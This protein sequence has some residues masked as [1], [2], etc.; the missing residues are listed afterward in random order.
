MNTVMTVF[1]TE[2]WR[3][4]YEEAINPMGVPEDAWCVPEDLEDELFLVLNHAE[5]LVAQREYGEHGAKDMRRLVL[6][7]CLGHRFAFLW[8]NMVF[9]CLSNG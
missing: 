2:F 8:C 9:V 6:E 4:G 7:W 5:L 1:K 3:V